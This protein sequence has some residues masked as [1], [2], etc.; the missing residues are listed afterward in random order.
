MADILTE[1]LN[2]ENVYFNELIGDINLAIVI[3]AIIILVICLKFDFDWE[4]IILTE[5]L[6][7]SIIYA[8]ITGMLIL[9]VIVVLIA[10]II[11]AHSIAAKVLK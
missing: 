10:S 1:Y 5:M 11:F 4:V 9:W 8:T 3:G 6:W 2:F 7:L